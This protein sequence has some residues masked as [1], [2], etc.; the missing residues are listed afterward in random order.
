MPITEILNELH[1]RRQG[2]LFSGPTPDW[3]RPHNYNEKYIEINGKKFSGCAKYASCDQIEETIKWTR[4]ESLTKGQKLKLKSCHCYRAS[5]V[6]H[7]SKPYALW[8]ITYISERINKAW[9]GNPF[10]IRKIDGIFDSPN[11]E[12]F[13]QRDKSPCKI[14]GCL[15]PEMQAE[16]LG[17]ASSMQ[18]EVELFDT[19]YWKD[20]KAC[21]YFY[22]AKDEKFDVF[23]KNISRFAQCYVTQ[24]NTRNLL[25]HNGF[26]TGAPLFREQ[27]HDKSHDVFWY[28]F[29]SGYS[30]VQLLYNVNSD[31][32]WHRFS[33][34]LRWHATSIQRVNVTNS[35]NKYLPKTRIA[36]SKCAEA[37]YQNFRFWDICDGYASWYL[38]TWILIQRYNIVNSI[39]IDFDNV[40]EW[41]YEDGID[42]YKKLKS[43]GFE[44]ELRLKLNILVN[45]ENTIRKSSLNDDLQLLGLFR[46]VQGNK[47]IPTKR[48]DY[49]ITWLKK[50]K[51]EDTGETNH[52]N[53]LKTN[54]LQNVGL[55]TET[56]ITYFNEYIKHLV[57][58]NSVE[59]FNN[60][61]LLNP[62]V[63]LIVRAFLSFPIRWCF[64]PFN[65][66]LDESEDSVLPTSATILLLE[67][68]LESKAYKPSIIEKDNII[69]KRISNIFPLLSAVNTIE[70]QNLR[71]EQEKKRKEIE[72]EKDKQATRAAISQVM[73]RNMSHNI[74]SHV[75]SN[76]VTEVSVKKNYTKNSE[77]YISLFNSLYGD[78]DGQNRTI[79]N[80]GFWIA[81]FNSYLRT[82]M[83][84]LADIATGEPAME[85]T[86]LLV[87][88]VL[89]EL[90]KN[91]ILLNH[92]SGVDNFKYSI[93]VKDCRKFKLPNCTNLDCKS[94]GIDK[95][96]PVSLPNSIMGYH[97]LFILIENVIRN[98]AKHQS[99]KSNS[100]PDDNI[101]K[102]FTLEIR[103]SGYDNTLYELLIYDN[104]EI[105]GVINVD[106]QLYRE[107]IKTDYSSAEVKFKTYL[108]RLVFQ[109]NR[110]I[111]DSI[112]NSSTNRLR[113]GAWG[114]VEM[115]ASAAY[116]RK[117]APESIDDD[118]YN[119]QLEDEEERL[120]VTNKHLNIIKAVKKGNHLAYRF[121]LMKPK[122]LLVIDE[123]GEVYNKLKKI[124]EG[125]K[126]K[127]DELLENGIWVK[128]R[129]N[130]D[131]I[132]YF[133]INLVYPHPFMLIITGDKFSLDEYLFTKIE[134]AAKGDN[135]LERSLFRGNLPSRMIVCRKTAD[136]EQS[137]SPWFTYINNEHQL[138]KY[139]YSAT[140]L[141]TKIPQNKSDLKLQTLMDIV[142]Q[143]WLKHKTDFHKIK[144]TGEMQNVVNRIKDYIIINSNM[145]NNFSVYLD[146]HGKDKKDVKVEA[147]K[148]EFSHYL[149]YP[150][151]VESFIKNAESDLSNKNPNPFFDKTGLATLADSFLTKILVID[152]RV[153]MSW[154]NPYSSTGKTLQELF[155]CG[156]LFSPK[157]KDDID[158]S[159]PFYTAEYKLKIESLITN[160]SQQGN[161]N[162][163]DYVLI[164]LGV[165]EKI[166]IANSDQKK[167]ENVLK[168]ILELQE[169]L[170]N[171]TRVV[172]TSGRG[173]PDNLPEQVPF[174]AFSTLS[175]Y[176]I[177]TP[178]K[179]FLNQIVQNARTFKS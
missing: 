21:P 112:I 125:K 51:N 158:L 69:L 24:Q 18:L 29:F 9:I 57:M 33:P 65:T 49:L 89:G 79:N 114:L 53:K 136:D 101:D 154:L 56:F 174:V 36:F 20:L 87:R 80:S 66:D 161:L 48:F 109:Q 128:Q 108:D 146:H 100:K 55:T 140:Q 19:T 62:P 160:I 4:W 94:N 177:E 7:K 74:G 107:H 111:N 102:V 121:H 63:H 168:F 92:I 90:D 46:K 99:G 75:L 78:I 104:I 34:Q 81:N 127:Y 11:N 82:R 16:Y 1:K 116:L 6:G 17:L 97:A 96:I 25:I 165:I 124:E 115:D 166:L 5:A 126:S 178:F 106:E 61:N 103:D 118:I 131:E 59:K 44:N 133:D 120:D 64:I 169:K 71:D 164:H 148:I 27:N 40:I 135:K 83:D 52:F 45:E 54:I 113:E 132:D 14:G 85:V 68:S 43:L 42:L 145:S 88:D 151:T 60:L 67:D 153:Q 58:T 47:L 30:Y 117:L 143:I 35:A 77:Q 167:K 129:F 22:R 149:A 3:C 50:E 23:E 8:D 110:R 170:P 86:R 76:M 119:L 93:A 130:S 31:P 157:K 95:D 72:V 175:Q 84:F 123:T 142:W 134:I 172:I 26:I 141:K 32:G 150:S 173:K 13:F 122:E 139:L 179:P 137:N 105:D 138:I 2:Y 12:Y 162:G 159:E 73:A 28:P 98:T 171:K 70:E 176:S 163:L 10:G 152:E 39:E 156:G 37:E 147:L 41:K 38:L 91:R 15:T 155:E 144:I